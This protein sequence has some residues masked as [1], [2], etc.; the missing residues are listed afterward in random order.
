V[1]VLD[2][3]HD[4]APLG[5]LDTGAGVDNLDYLDDKG[6][7]YVAASRAARLTVARVDDKG[8]LAVVATGETAEGARNAVA[9]ANGRA[10]LVDGAGARLFVFDAPP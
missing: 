8:Q 6:L 2:A 9:D 5:K 7:L 1:Q 10:Y 4:G 3:G